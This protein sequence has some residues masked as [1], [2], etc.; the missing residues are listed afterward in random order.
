[1]I[2]QSSHGANISIIQLITQADIVVQIV[3][4]VLILAS[5]WSWAIIFDKI[6]KFKILHFRTTRFEKIFD[7]EDTI[8]EIHK[9]IK[10]K[11]NHPL[12]RIFISAINEWRSSVSKTADDKSSIKE[13][14]YNIMHITSVKSSEKLEAGLHYLAIIGS[15]S[16]FIGLFGTVWG[17]MNSFQAIAVS[18]NTN[19]SVVAPG[20]AEALLATAMGLFAAI[21]AVIFY[22]IYSNK[23][24]NFSEKMDNFISY[25]LNIF[26]HELD[27]K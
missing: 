16:P 6:I 2:D 19:L 3:M 25:V 9:N 14:L 21:P 8:E 4:L 23:I 17:I 12:A 26:S 7:S 13:R 5:I 18:K 27:K 22:N 15:A 24:N 1:M 10:H 11:N 20:I